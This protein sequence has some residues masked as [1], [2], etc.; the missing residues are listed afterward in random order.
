MKAVAAEI[1]RL[2]RDVQKLK[3][4]RDISKKSRGLVR[5]G[6]DVMFAFMA[7]HRGIWPLKTIKHLVR[8]I[9]NPAATMTTPLTF[10]YVGAEQRYFQ[11]RVVGLELPTGHR[12]D[13]RV[14]QIDVTAQRDELLATAIA[15]IAKS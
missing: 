12:N 7:K 5:Q 4:E 10:R 15:S 2:K 14:Q 1:E 11:R 13:A 9:A 3:T 8:S 6:P